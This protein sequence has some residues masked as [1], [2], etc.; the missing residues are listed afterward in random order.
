MLA[1]LGGEVDVLSTGLGETLSYLASGDVRLL[2]VGAHL[3]SDLAPDVPTLTELGV[4]VVFANWRGLFAAPGVLRRQPESPD[5]TSGRATAAWQDP[6]VRYG[7]QSAAARGRLPGVSR[8]PRKQT[9][10]VMTDL[11]FLH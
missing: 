11:G 4:P 9:G 10:V 1:L 8:M 7:W 5:R 3:A 6:G 2:A